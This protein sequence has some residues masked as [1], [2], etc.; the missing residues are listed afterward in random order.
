MKDI[1]SLMVLLLVG[2]AANNA[3]AQVFGAA[4][5][6]QARLRRHFASVQQQMNSRSTDGLGPAVAQKR[7]AI[8]QKLGQYSE[9]GVFPRNT[10]HP[11]TQTPYFIDDEG[12]ACA[13][14]YL[15]IE[16]GYETA[17]RAIAGSQNNAYVRDIRSPAL[18]PWLKE[19]GV[20]VEEAALIQPSYCTIS[21]PEGGEPVCGDDGKSYRNECIA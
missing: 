12:R 9:R 1:V 20:S 18:A 4:E 6:E 7:R 10:R 11:N 3:A 14:G 17:A 5:A 13:V 16:S 21:C 8:I 2:L 15:M 19:H